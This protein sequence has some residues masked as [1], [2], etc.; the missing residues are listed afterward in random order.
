MF[1]SEDI[2]HTYTRAEALN[3][4]T[5]LDA[6]ETATEAGFRFPVALTRAAWEDCVAWTE[7]DT[8]TTGHPQDVEGR[9][10]DVLTMARYGIRKAGTGQSRVSFAL[11]RVPRGAE[12]GS[13]PTQQWLIAEVSGG[14]HGEPVVT[15]M[16]PGEE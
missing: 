1:I 9:L 7:Q 2:I 5:L 11:Y 8:E 12:P 4:G 16:F 10:W 6:T 15:L 3:D 13:G 14:D